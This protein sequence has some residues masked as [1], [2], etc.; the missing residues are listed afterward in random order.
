MIQANNLKL[1]L[2]D[3][4]VG[5]VGVLSYQA[6]VR[7]VNF[8]AG[9]PAH[10]EVADV[11]KALDGPVIVGDVRRVRYNRDT[12]LFEYTDD[13]TTFSQ[14]APPPVPDLSPYLQR[15]SAARPGVTKLYWNDN[16][17]AYNIQTSFDGTR[18]L[19]QGYNG[20]TYH[21]PARVA[22]AAAA[23]NA[24][25]AANSSSLGGY[26]L[27]S[28]QAFGSTVYKL[29]D[30][31]GLN[32]VYT[33][34]WSGYYQYNVANWDTATALYAQRTGW[35]L[36]VLNVNI[37]PTANT[38]NLAA[39]ILWNGTTRIGQQNDRRAANQLASYLSASALI[40]VSAGQYVQAQT[41]C[42][43]GITYNLTASTIYPF[44]SLISLEAA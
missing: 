26:A 31:N 35:H 11:A 34:V 42:G 15:T 17:S 30:T 41:T 28:L 10:A 4:E 22:Y 8:T 7:F 19:L 33:I 12:N 39:W 29:A 32:G 16:D 25:L 43:G 37:T 2:Q 9:S 6:N 44:F 3:T 23:A 5:S 13:G 21:A 20:D 36:A 40:Y 27:V 1:S 24:T 14:V 18:W 38:D